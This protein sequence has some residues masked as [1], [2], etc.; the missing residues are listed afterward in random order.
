MTDNIHNNN[1][2]L[3]QKPTINGHLQDKLVRDSITT[4]KILRHRCKHVKA[5]KLIARLIQVLML[6]SKTA[7]EITLHKSKTYQRERHKAN[8]P[9]C[10][11]ILPATTPIT[12]L[13]DN[14]SAQNTNRQTNTF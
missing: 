11:I 4:I 5:M 9:L 3:D 2:H 14:A 12:T 1:A 6:A 8:K 10:Q 13:V 7:R